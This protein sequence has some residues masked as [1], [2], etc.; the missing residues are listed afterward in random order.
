LQDFF[1]FWK[2]ADL[3]IPILVQAQAEYARLKQRSSQVLRSAPDV[4]SERLSKF[5]QRLPS[6]PRLFFVR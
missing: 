1:A 3:D 2:N 4:F 5:V 6:T